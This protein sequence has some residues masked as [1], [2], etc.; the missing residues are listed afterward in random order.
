[1]ELTPWV[2]QHEPSR[3]LSIRHGRPVFVLFSEQGSDQ[4]KTRFLGLK[5]PRNDKRKMVWQSSAPL[6][7][8]S[9]VVLLPKR[10]SGDGDARATRDVGQEEA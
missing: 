6:R 9:E 5:P 1:M 2:L 3:S 10:T 7:A 8:D 4:F